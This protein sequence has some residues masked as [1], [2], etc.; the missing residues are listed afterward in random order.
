MLCWR[1][2][3]LKQPD[4][5]SSTQKENVINDYKLRLTAD[6]FTYVFETWMFLTLDAITH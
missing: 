6:S 4:F 5:I 3:V 2:L 1:P